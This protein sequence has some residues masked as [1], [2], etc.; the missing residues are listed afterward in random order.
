MSAEDCNT[1]RSIIKLYLDDNKD[2]SFGHMVSFLKSNEDAKQILTKYGIIIPLRAS[3]TAVTTKPTKAIEA[4]KDILD[5]LMKPAAVGERLAQLKALFPPDTNE[6]NDFESYH[7]SAFNS[8]SSPLGNRSNSNSN[9]SG[10]TPNSPEDDSCV[11]KSSTGETYEIKHR[12]VTQKVRN[13]GHQAFDAAAPQNQTLEA[14]NAMIGAE[15]GATYDAA[16]EKNPVLR[17]GAERDI[18]ICD[19]FKFSLECL[20]ADG[21][22]SDCFIHSFLLATCKNFRAAKVAKKPYKAFATRFRKT[23]VPLIVAHVCST[24][25]DFKGKKHSLPNGRE[26]PL[27]TLLK[28]ELATPSEFLD[29]ALI[30]VIC[31]YYKICIIVIGPGTPRVSRLL[32]FSEAKEVVDTYHPA[33]VISNKKGVHWEPVRI[34]RTGPYLLDKDQAQCIVETYKGQPED[35]EEKKAIERAFNQLDVIKRIESKEDLLKSFLA[36]ETTAEGVPYTKK[37]GKSVNDKGGPIDNTP[38]AVAKL[39]MEKDATILALEAL[40]DRVRQDYKDRGLFAKEKLQQESDALTKMLKDQQILQVKKESSRLP[41][42]DAMTKKVEAFIPKQESSNNEDEDEDDED[43]D[44]EG[45]E[46]LTNESKGGRR[47]R[48]RRRTQRRRTRRFA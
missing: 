23:M 10:K 45:F 4:C 41:D 19:A 7:E 46:S 21:T 6:E 35:P 27:E 25:P 13:K 48:R 30:R 9:S 11:C 20:H 5:I 26:E 40:K 44:E 33:Y 32:Y 17:N 31:A 36:N 28:R 47:S 43:D 14:L 8:N 15:L 1:L 24:N 38:G 37:D 18:F 22:N 29:D 3:S 42:V 16:I 12:R 2:E 34:S 39:Y